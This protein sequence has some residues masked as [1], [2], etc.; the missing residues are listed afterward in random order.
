MDPADVVPILLV[1]FGDS[2]VAQVLEPRLR[3]AGYPVLTLR[4]LSRVSTLVAKLPKATVVVFDQ[5]ESGAAERTLSLVR[6]AHCGCAVVVVVPHADFSQYYSL[7]NQ[8]AIGYF[9][10]QEPPSLIFA[11]VTLAASRAHTV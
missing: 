4:D 3:K 2:P 7:M 9:E 10:A 11:G 5:G 6:K 8:G 1:G